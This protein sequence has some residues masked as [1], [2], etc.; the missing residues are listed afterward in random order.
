MI[1]FYK[2]SLYMSKKINNDNKIYFIINSKFIHHLDLLKTTFKTFN[3]IK[4]INNFNIDDNNIYIAINFNDKIKK[5]VNDLL[6]YI[7]N[8]NDI[9]KKINIDVNIYY[10]YYQS[11]ILIYKTNNIIKEK[12]KFIND[13]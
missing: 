12:I 8:I 11:K 10:K 4:N 6:P 9:L 7:N 2:K 13:D 1:K 5:D 3:N